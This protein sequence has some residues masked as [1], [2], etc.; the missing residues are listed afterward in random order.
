MWRVG[1][2]GYRQEVSKVRVVEQAR[3]IPWSRDALVVFKL[4]TSPGQEVNTLWEA[5]CSATRYRERPVLCTG[6][7]TLID[8]NYFVVVSPGV[9]RSERRSFQHM[10][11]TSMGI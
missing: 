7:P 1:L 5:Q 10:K 11:L 6:Q 8:L 2:S 4:G 3:I 9:G